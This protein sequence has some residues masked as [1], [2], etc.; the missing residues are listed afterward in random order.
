MNK[1]QKK[2]FDDNRE[3]ITDIIKV[4]NLEQK[5]TKKTI[6]VLAYNIAFMFL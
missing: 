4:M 5:L 1:E 6:D 3:K 2:S